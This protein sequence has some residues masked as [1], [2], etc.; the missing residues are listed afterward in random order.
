[1]ALRNHRFLRYAVA[2]VAAYVVLQGLVYGF[3]HQWRPWAAQIVIGLVIAG[4]LAS[5]MEK[6]KTF[7]WKGGVFALLIAS[8]LVIYALG[9][10]FL[11]RGYIYNTIGFAMTLAFTALFLL[12]VCKHRFA[13]VLFSLLCAA[14]LVPLLLYWGYYAIAGCPL[15]A[16]ALLA[17]YQ[18][19]PEEAKG[20]LTNFLPISGGIMIIIFIVAYASF[21]G[22]G[23]LHR[24]A[25]AERDRR[26]LM[27]FLAVALLIAGY[28]CQANNV[29]YILAKETRE[30][31]EQYQ[32]FAAAQEERKA[33]GVSL[34]SVATKHPGVYILVIGESQNRHHMSA[35]GYEKET[36]PW[37]E[38]MKT[39]PH[40]IFFT[41]GHSCFVT[42]SQSLSYVLTS[43]NQY[44]DIP[45]E[46]SWTLMKSVKAAGGKTA[47]FSNQVRYGALDTPNT[48]IASEA[49]Q[50]QWLNNNM[51][52]T[53]DTPW[54]DEKLAEVLQEADHYDNQLIV[55][56]LI[57]NHGDYRDRYPKAYAVD[58]PE[59]KKANAYDN[60]MRYND[61][62]V[63][64][65]Y[66]VAKTVPHFQALVY[67]SDHAED[68]EHGLGHDPERYT[69]DMADIP[70]YVLVSDEYM[71]S[72]PEKV[73]TLRAHRGDVFTNDLIYNLVLGLMGIEFPGIYEENNDLTNPAYDASPE[74][75]RTLGGEQALED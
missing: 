8:P 50:Q 75:F 56:H 26:R 6:P 4:M 62:V 53:F 47:W 32:I 35:Y 51:G 69:Q 60:S 40:M 34:P 12:D 28:F 3:L 58:Q 68:I 71:A 11:T 20:F 48:V 59:S 70:F 46:Q 36:T 19:N 37:L 9:G 57:G 31:I 74:R 52:V 13:S 64:K 38:T 29:Y 44:N 39:D 24:D 16:T 25:I 1:M 66:E 15:G 54:Y 17:I 55:L 72:A 61:E 14:L 73:D 23:L 33:R 30:G 5:L 49:D 65:I 2:I 43:K 18:T 41:K 7:L 21:V 45:L 10:N 22:K 42:T 67:M 63:R 27:K